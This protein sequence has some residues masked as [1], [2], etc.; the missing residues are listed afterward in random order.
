MSFNDNNSKFEEGLLE[1][2]I[3]LAFASLTPY[4]RKLWE[5]TAVGS[6]VL[7]QKLFRA[8]GEKK[9]T[10]CAYALIVFDNSGAEPDVAAKCTISREIDLL[11]LSIAY[12][13]KFYCVDSFILENPDNQTIAREFSAG[14]QSRAVEIVCLGFFKDRL[15]P[16]NDAHAKNIFSEAVKVI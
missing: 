12:A 10:E 13:A 8:T 2:I 4:S 15:L 7:L 6:P 14:R 9:V 3:N 1:K 16:K 5:I 11:S